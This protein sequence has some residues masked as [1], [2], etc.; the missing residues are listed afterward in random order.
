MVFASNGRQRSLSAARMDGSAKLSGDAG[1]ARA[2][3]SHV[4]GD[5]CPEQSRTGPKIAAAAGA[6][7]LL[8]ASS[9]YPKPGNA[10]SHHAAAQPTMAA[11]AVFRR[12][13]ATRA[14]RICDVAKAAPSEAA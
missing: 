2:A 7:D 14:P 9:V 10:A 3:M 1:P 11:A 6:A 13:E 5:A 4:C 8:L 12:A